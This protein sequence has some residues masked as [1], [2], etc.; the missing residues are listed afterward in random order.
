MKR[1]TLLSGSALLATT[2]LSTAAVAGAFV[3]LVAAGGI[4]ATKMTAIGLS[5]QVFGGTAPE[6]LVLGGSISG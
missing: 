4:V 5:A 6:T 2:A 1:Q 3:P